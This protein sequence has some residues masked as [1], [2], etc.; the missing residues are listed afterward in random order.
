MMGEVSE[1]GNWYSVVNT[2]LMEVAVEEEEE[3]E[4][5]LEC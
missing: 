2:Y 3:E 1:E 4:H 5:Y